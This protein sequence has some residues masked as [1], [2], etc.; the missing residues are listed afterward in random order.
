MQ[1]LNAESVAK[2]SLDPRLQERHL[3][4]LLL[5]LLFEVSG[6]LSG[7]HF[8]SKFSTQARGS[9]INNKLNKYIQYIICDTGA[10]GL[11]ASL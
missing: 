3:H 10:R 8:L 4:L 11:G 7:S 9:L 2:E 5:A 1:V 6:V